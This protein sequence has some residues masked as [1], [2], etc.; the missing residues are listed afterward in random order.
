VGREDGADAHEIEIREM[1]VAQRHLEA[2][3]FFLVPANTLRQ[4]GLGRD[5]HA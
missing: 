1:G 5:E 4:K 2:G 3:E